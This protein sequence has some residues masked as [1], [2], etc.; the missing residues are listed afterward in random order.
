MTDDRRV[1]A[2]ASR[3]DL[4]NF[5]ITFAVVSGVIAAWLA[6]RGRGNSRAFA[7]GATVFAVISAL[8]P[9]MLR[10]VHGPWMKFA[11]ALG[12]FNTRLLLTLFFFVGL[13][14]MGALMRILGK[15]P[16]NRTFKQKGST[17]YWNPVPKHPDGVRHFDRQF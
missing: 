16:M 4:R 12:E 2:A 15:D 11:A 9:A 6:W 13:T 1:P 3:R 7:L 10:P 17:S 14:P 5:G 8:A